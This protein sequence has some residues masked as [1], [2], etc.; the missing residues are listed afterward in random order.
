MLTIFGGLPGV[1]KTSVARELARQIGAVYLPIDSIE[2]AI[3]TS[4]VVSEP[5][6]DAG[7]RDRIRSCRR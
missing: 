4:G 7:Y 3:R 1:G 6:N 5:L 2:Q